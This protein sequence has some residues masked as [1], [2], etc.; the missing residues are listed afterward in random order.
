MPPFT[1]KAVDKVVNPRRI[2]SVLWLALALGF[3]ISVVNTLY[4]SYEYGA[5]NLGNMGMKRAGPLAFDFV[6]AEIRNPKPPGGDGRVMWAIIGIGLMAI[7]T[8]IR[9]WLPWWPLHPIGL[10]VQ[11]NFGVCRTVFSIMIAWGMKAVVLKM[12]GVQMYEKGKPFFIGLLVAQ[13]VSTGLV[14]TIDWFW[15]PMRG[16]NVHNY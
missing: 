15:F 9:Y 8:M 11:G 14:F 16:H 1:V 13:A 12:G 5:Y 2:T 4:L 3:A 6:L 7:L 10:A